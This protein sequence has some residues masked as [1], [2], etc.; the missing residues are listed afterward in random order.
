MNFSK[1][2]KYSFLIFGGLILIG[3]LLKG[4]I[5]HEKFD[6]EKWKS[7][8]EGE[9]QWS[10]RWDMMNSLRNSYDLKLMNKQEIT[11]LLGKPESETNNEFYYNLVKEKVEFETES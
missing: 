10:L 6:S 4:N 2:I 7:W 11:D 9:L 8:E 1:F 5:I 3:F